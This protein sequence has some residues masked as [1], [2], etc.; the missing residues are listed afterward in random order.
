MQQ[1]LVQGHVNHTVSQQEGL[2]Q[3]EDSHI[4]VD[5]LL[6]RIRRTEHVR[7]GESLHRE[8]F[9]RSQDLE[10]QGDLLALHMRHR[11]RKHQV[12]VR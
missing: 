7:G 8:R 9:P 4:P 11:H 3:G 5:H 12:C 2:V 6:S 10:L 1:S